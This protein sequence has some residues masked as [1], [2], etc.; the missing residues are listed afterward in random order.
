M[1]QPEWP[2][3]YLEYLRRLS[4]A[5]VGDPKQ[6]AIDR[7]VAAYLDGE[8]EMGVEHLGWLPDKEGAD[9]VAHPED[10][11]ALLG[12]LEQLQED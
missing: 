9:V 4:E 3:G 10:E 8:T 12:D 11:P 2:E 7:V 5:E 6:E 1:T